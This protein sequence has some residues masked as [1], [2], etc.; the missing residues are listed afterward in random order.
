MRFSVGLPVDRVDCIDEFVTGPAVMEMAAAAEAAGFDACFVTDHPA[1]DDQWL[2]TGGHHA[3]EPFVALAFAAAGTTTL[4]LQTHVYVAAYRNPFLAAKGV[5]SLDALSGGRVILGVAAGYLRPEFGALGVDFDE[6]NELLDESIEVMKR[7]WTEDQ[8]AF[9]GRHFRARGVTMRPRP[10]SAPHPP[11]WIGGNS[12]R[13]LR[14]AVES[15]QGWVPF[16]NPPQAARAVK[17]P[18]IT[19][20]D[21]LGERMQLVAE[22]SRAVGRTDPLDICFAPFHHDDDPAAYEALGVTWLA[23]GFSADTRAEWIDTMRAYA[24][25]RL[26]GRGS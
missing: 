13:A 11:I 24:A 6:R 2:V 4:R 5:S 17:T 12:T 19:N 1:A 7:V 18:A 10:V 22:H 8:V 20:L 9:E 3:L 16:P 14:R 21:E 25:S 15:A 26:A 23:V